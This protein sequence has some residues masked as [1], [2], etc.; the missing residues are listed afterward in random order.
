VEEVSLQLAGSMGGE[1]Y[2]WR[3]ME[4]SRCHN[5]FQN[6]NTGL[7]TLPILEYTQQQGR[8]SVTGGYVYRGQAYPWLDGIYFF[9]DFCTGEIWGALPDG[10]G[11][12]VPQNAG[13]RA[14]EP[15]DTDF[16]ISTF[17]ED[18]AGELYVADFTAGAIYRI[19][20]PPGLPLLSLAGLVNAASFDAGLPLAAGA[21][22][23]L[24]VPALSNGIVAAPAIPLATQLD[25]LTVRF[26]GIPAPL[27]LVAPSQFN[28][29]I[30]WELAALDQATI[31][32]LRDGVVSP[33]QLQ[34]A[35]ATVSPGIF[36]LTQTGS[37]Q[38]AALI[39][40][41]A[42]AIAAPAGAYPGSRP[43]RIGEALEIFVTGLGATTNQPLT[44]EAS[45]GGPLAAALAE[46]T[47]RVGVEPARVL[48]AGLT[49]GLVGLYQV[50]VELVGDFPSGDAIEIV[51]T[52]DGV[53]ANPATIA[54]E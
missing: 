10:P 33:E 6:C 18:E 15:L 39:S 45:P 54:I 9:G 20:A 38:A 24:F 34:V 31:T 51:L 30:P 8:C 41:A 4:G 52:V 2:G 28:L 7:L 53:E 12:G 21:I 19:A 35:L 1:N 49:P 48:F 13:W 3:L 27:Y 47:V 5:P 16:R 26:N 50:N 14:L 46:V 29:Q 25:G 44:G 32:A 43:A 42:G 11:P 22:G 17:G 23:S 40:G 37:G 36:T